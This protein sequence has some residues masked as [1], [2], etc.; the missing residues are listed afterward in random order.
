MKKFHPI[1]ESGIKK[2]ATRSTERSEKTMLR[3]FL[4]AQLKDL[5]WAEKHLLTALPKMKEAATTPLLMQAFSNHLIVTEKQVTKLEKVFTLLEEKAQS[6]KCEAMEELTREADGMIEDTE[7]GTLTRDVSL[8]LAAQ[9]VEH[10]EI[11]SYG[12]LAQLARMIG[13]TE[14]AALLEEILQEERDADDAL[15]KL[16][17]GNVSE[18]PLRIEEEEEE[19]DTQELEDAG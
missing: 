11:A 5:Y 1:A 14:I 3:D 9:R 12:S 18:A 15:T 4:V 19:E 10:Y 6:S 8:I 16:T 13:E 7:E 2:A 17:I